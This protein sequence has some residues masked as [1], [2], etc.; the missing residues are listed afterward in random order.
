MHNSIDQLLVTIDVP[1]RE[2]MMRLTENRKGIVLVTDSNGM[3]VTTVTDGD[4]RRALLAGRRLEDSVGTLVAAKL[5]GVY[6]VPITA[7]LGVTREELLVLMERAKVRHV[8]LVDAEGRVADVVTL[9]ELIPTRPRSFNAVVMAG[10]QGKRLRPLTEHVPKP[11]LPV[12]GRPVMEYIVEQLRD[13]GTQRIYVSTN[14]QSE[15]IMRHF[16]DGEGFGVEIRYL[17]EQSPLGTGG[18]LGLMDRPSDPVLVINGD[19]LTR[20]DLRSLFAFHEDHH[21]DLTLA[22]RRYEMQVPYG[23][24]EAEGARVTGLREKPYL[25]FFINA[26]IYLIEPCVFDYIPAP[27]HMNMTDLVQTLLHDSRHVVSFPICEYW[28]DMGQHADY[29]Q[30]DADAKNGEFDTTISR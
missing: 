16:G 15:K 3:F 17:E 20:V 11:L 27:V 29:L 6:E 5:G 22:V 9:E 21:A 13:L 30:A 26:G 8:P 19:V 1:I 24:V 25:T 23:V 2:A 18:A 10:G 28:I 14:Y 4:I 12:G 7:P